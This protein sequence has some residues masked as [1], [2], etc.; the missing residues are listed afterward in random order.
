MKLHRFKFIVLHIFLPIALVLFWFIASLFLN[1]TYSFMTLI[2]PY[3]RSQLIQYPVG[4]FLKGETIKGEFTAKENYLGLI[5]LRFKDYIKHDYREED[6]INFRIREK[7]SPNWYYSNDYWSGS[8]E[9]QLR[10]PFGFPAIIDSKDKKYEF[11]LTSLLGKNN[12][13]VE[14]YVSDPQLAAVHKLPKKSIFSNPKSIIGFLLE[15]IVNS[16]TNVDF[17]LRSTLYA[18]PFFIFLF[19]RGLQK[20]V[21]RKIRFNAIAVS[22]I[23]IDIFCVQ[24]FYLGILCILALGWFVSIR[25]YRIASKTSYV[26]AFILFTLWLPLMYF[27]TKYIQNK[28]NIWVYFF[29]FTGTIQAIIEEKY[30]KGIHTKISRKK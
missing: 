15:K 4:K 10:F 14:L 11:E 3:P 17:L 21:L 27:S 6:L 7:K 29:L 20:S 16:F 18:V 22:V 12:N 25:E 13:A 30:P 5:T 26:I 24:E 19:L 9:N 28:L 8:I 1:N 23:A 2:Y